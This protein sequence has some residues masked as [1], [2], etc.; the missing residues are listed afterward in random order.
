VV[1]NYDDASN[2]IPN[3]FFSENATSAH[4]SWRVLDGALAPLSSQSCAIVV[5]TTGV[6]FYVGTSVGLYSTTNPNGNNTQWLREGSGMMKI[7]IIRSLVN[8]PEDNTLLVGT[9]GN[10]A[11]MADIGSAVLYSGNEVE[12]NRNGNDFIVSLHPTLTPNFVRYRVGSLPVT[13][14]TVQL[15]NAI[16][17]EVMREERAYQN[18]VVDLERY[19]AGMYFLRIT[20]SDGQHKFVQRILKR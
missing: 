3:I 8:R 18:N 20:S 15:F 16:G 12:P 7:A 17:Q 6:E 4:P 9:H 19:A 2:N 10:G 1:S 13:K 11:F 14:I 5:K